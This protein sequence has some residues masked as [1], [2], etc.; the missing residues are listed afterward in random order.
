LWHYYLNKPFE[1]FFL[2]LVS[3]RARLAPAFT[4][5]NKTTNTK[6]CGGLTIVFIIA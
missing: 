3:C 1:F 6:L 4:C 2:F 5:Q